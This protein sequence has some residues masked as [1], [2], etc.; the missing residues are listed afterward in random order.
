MSALRKVT[1]RESDAYAAM[2]AA[3]AAVVQR[4]LDG[5]DDDLTERL[6]RRAQATRKEWESA[7]RALEDATLRHWERVS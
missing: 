5:V 1:K 7:A 6:R 4:L 3:S 2:Q